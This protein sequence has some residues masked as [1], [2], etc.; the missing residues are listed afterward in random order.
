MLISMPLLVA[1]SIVFGLVA[2]YM[3][4]VYGFDVPHAWYWPRTLEHTDMRDLSCGMIKGLVFGVIITMVS[5][6]Q[7]L[8]AENG[9]VGVGLGTTRAVVTASLALLVINLFLTVLLNNFFPL[10]AL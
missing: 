4:A 1:E 5:C 3:V 2:S 10:S 8:R 9:A 6:H 7:G